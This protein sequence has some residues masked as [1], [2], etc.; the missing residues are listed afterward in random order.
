[1]QNKVIAS[2]LFSV[3]LSVKA[4][5]A[6]SY[7]VNTGVLAIPLVK[8]GTSFFRN[9]QITLGEIKYAELGAPK[10]QFDEYDASKNLLSIPSVKVG[11][12]IYTN[13]GVTVGQVLCINCP[14][15]YKEVANITWRQFNFLAY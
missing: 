1:M 3:F 10:A 15:P 13:V 6:D 7:D 14:T 2:L 5:A 12:L 4:T 9:V 11:D 8:V